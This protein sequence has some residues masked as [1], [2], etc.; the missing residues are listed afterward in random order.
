MDKIKA[1]KKETE[2][3]LSKMIGK[4]ELEVTKDED[5]YHVVIKTD[6]DAP[7]VIGRH[8]ETIRAL[9]KIL[10]VVLYKQFGES[11]ELLVNVNDYRE[12]Q[13]ER[14]ESLAQRTAEKVADFKSP[15]YLKGLSSYERKIVHEYVVSNFPDLASYSVGEG[16]DRRLV[17]NL[18]GNEEEEQ[19]S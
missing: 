5:M 1:I 9:Q 2:A 7:T 18:K 4:Y 3:I 11:V 8:G 15:S 16:G 12:R 19:T 14:L 13:K 17:I 10:E 6:E